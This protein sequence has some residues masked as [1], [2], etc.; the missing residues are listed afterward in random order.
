MKLAVV[1]VHYHTAELAA[2]ALDALD[3]D[4]G[5]AGVEAERIL[6]DNGS[7]AEE[8]ERLR[9][10][11][12]RLL[13]PDGGRN[14]GYAG[15]ANLGIGSSAAE[16]VILMNP[17]V[18]VLPGCVAA[19][20]DALERGAAVAGPR[21]YWDRARRFL[22][23]P[24]E[25]RTRLDELL[26]LAGERS[27]F[28]AHLGRR[29]W[30]RHVHLYRTSPARRRSYE[31]SGALLAFHRRTWEE[32]GGFD[33]GY[34]LY[35]E[36][37]DFLER[38]RRRRGVALY[39]PEAEAVHLYAQSTLGEPRAGGWFVE[40]ARRFRRRF[41]GAVFSDLLES[42]DRVWARRERTGAL[43]VSRRGSPAWLELS[44][45]AVGYPAAARRWDGPATWDLDAEI[46][47]R[48]GAGRY[49][50]RTVDAAGRELETRS[51]EL[52]EAAPGAGTPAG[53]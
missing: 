17:D 2:A 5:G 9:D 14:L 47:A 39:V 25:R 16:A 10:L 48:V 46:A 31:L 29:R 37:S 38:L 6:V 32:L 33:E 19:L 49:Y 23:P 11:G 26:R 13:C 36:E 41:Y 1:L 51:L 24:N 40:S 45:A 50:L 52:G 35:F 20:L 42:L 27:A 28:W 12:V 3:A 4:L 7:T 34:R 15:G 43:G 8:R 44:A 22:L 30:R 18:E 21:F 53:E